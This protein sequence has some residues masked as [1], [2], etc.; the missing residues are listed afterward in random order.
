MLWISLSPNDR[1]APPE[2]AS[3]W[4]ARQRATQIREPEKGPGSGA[5]P[6]YAHQTAAGTH[7]RH[8][9][10]HLPIRRVLLAVSPQ[11]TGG[12]KLINRPYCLQAT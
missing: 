2:L 5:P 9:V 1:R 10:H 6:K 3:R 11:I 12:D 8:R 7:A 4:L